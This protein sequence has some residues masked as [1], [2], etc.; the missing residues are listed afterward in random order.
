MLVHHVYQ[1]CPRKPFMFIWKS[2]SWLSCMS[3]WAT[4]E[5]ACETQLLYHLNHWNLCR[6]HV[7]S[8]DATVK[9]DKAGVE[10][11]TVY[12][13]KNHVTDLSWYKN[14][15]PKCLQKTRAEISISM[16]NFTKEINCF[17]FATSK[18]SVNLVG[19]SFLTTDA[20]FFEL[21]SR[22]NYID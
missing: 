19:K 20:S 5:E 22:K 13:A 3:L 18:Y 4:V 14:P 2:V 12:L 15:G 10:A 6:Q 9:Q 17:C 21:L 8:T 7:R 16:N 1:L 11:V